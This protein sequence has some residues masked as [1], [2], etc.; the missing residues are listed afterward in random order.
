MSM[1]IISRK[2]SRLVRDSDTSS[3]ERPPPLPQDASSPAPAPS[4]PGDTLKRTRTQCDLE[5]LAMVDAP[6]AWA[7]DVDA[8]LASPRL[9]TPTGSALDAHDNWARYTRGQSAFVL[10]VQGSL[11]LH[12][13]L[14]W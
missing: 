13:E 1:P 12:Y 2:R 8:L 10:C 4:A 11:Q 3:D 9:A 7:F 14:L 6:A 5:D